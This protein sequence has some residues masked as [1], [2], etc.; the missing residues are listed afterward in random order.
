MHPNFVHLPF[1][2]WEIMDMWSVLLLDTVL[3]M[4]LRNMPMPADEPRLLWQWQHPKLGESL[5]N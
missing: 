5:G 4:H 2:E 3:I 1:F